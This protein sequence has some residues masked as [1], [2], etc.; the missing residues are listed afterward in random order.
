ME[1][2]E[3]AV[4]RRTST[5]QWNQQA[6]SG[7]PR[8]FSRLVRPFVFTVGVGHVYLSVLGV[9]SSVRLRTGVNAMS[10][11]RLLLWLG[12]H[13]AVWVFKVPSP[14]LLPRYESRLAREA[15]ASETRGHPQRGENRKQEVRTTEKSYETVSKPNGGRVTVPYLIP[16]CLCFRSTSGG[17]GWVRVRRRSQVRGWC[18]LFVCLTAENPESCLLIHMYPVLFS[19]VSLLLMR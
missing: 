8:A 2:S 13:L 10:V 12:G 17:I 14:E 18:F 4:N 3:A 9:T 1:S 7:S 16:D 6:P 19:Q 15:A 11:Y 5:P